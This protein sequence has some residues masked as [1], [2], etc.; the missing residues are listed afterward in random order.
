MKDILDSPYV[1]L[2]WIPVAFLAIYNLAYLNKFFMIVH[3]GTIAVRK[4][5]GKAVRFVGELGGTGFWV[6]PKTGVIHP[7][8]DSKPLFM[9]INILGTG[10][11]WLGVW[12]IATRHTYKLPRNK[13]VKKG[14]GADY[15]FENPHDSTVDS[16]LLRASYGIVISAA[17]THPSEKVPI[18]VR[19]LATFMVTDCR[20][21]LFENISPD[22]L[23]RATGMI[24][25]AGRDFIGNHTLDSI[26]GLDAEGSSDGKGKSSFQE[27]MMKINTGSP[28][29]PCIQE[30]AGHRLV[31]I[32]FLDYE[33][34]EVGAN[35]TQKASIKRYFATQEASAKLVASEADAKARLIAAEADVRIAEQKAKEIAILAEAEAA[36]IQREGA[37]KAA[38]AKAFAEANANNP[39]AGT[40]AIAEALR[41]TSATTV[42][43][44]PG[45]VPTMPVTP[46]EKK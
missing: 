33:I 20:I 26:T 45:V 22:W 36:R 35:E 1:H 40:F 12:P 3:S 44:G 39:H 4:K 2:I 31:A 25:A 27:Y 29:N 24:E 34:A 7:D 38:A 8:S 11:Y 41:E 42:V 5:S 13:Y 10:I 23:A 19:L 43:M 16:V 17:E 30:L 28:D 21:A 32:S 46:E 18:N 9:P 15:V 37:A 14:D 6:H